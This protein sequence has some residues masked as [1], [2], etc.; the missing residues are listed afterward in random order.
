MWY[1]VMP[2]ASPADQMDVDWAIELAEA[3]EELT[4]PQK[5][6][7]RDPVSCLEKASDNWSPRYKS[8]QSLESSIE[9]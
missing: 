7:K 9:T 3:L 8:F 2:L 4:F 1:A 6:W 5:G